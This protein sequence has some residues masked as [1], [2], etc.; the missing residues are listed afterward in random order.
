MASKSY[1]D[2]KGLAA[3]DSPGVRISICRL[4]EWF[5][6]HEDEEKVS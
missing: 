2:P 3:L 6:A 1:P 4:G 5:D